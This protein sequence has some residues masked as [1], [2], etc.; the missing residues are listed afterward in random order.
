MAG[1]QGVAAQL[2]ALAQHGL[3]FGGSA[4]VDQ[5]EAEDLQ[6][7]RHHRVGVRQDPPAQRERLP[8][9]RLRLPGRPRA[10]SRYASA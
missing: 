4:L 10:R 3:G 1:G 7:A 5:A 2:E 6:D 9:Q 8:A